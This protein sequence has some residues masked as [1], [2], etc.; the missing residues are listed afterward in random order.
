MKKSYV[1]KI[2][3]ANCA[4]KVENAI[5]QIEGVIS[6]KASFMAEKLVLEAEDDK[7]DAV[8]EEVIKTAKKIEPDCE[9]RA[10]GK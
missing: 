2:D 1:F 5:R 8:F 6:A 9:I 3:C 7:F 4:A 10:K